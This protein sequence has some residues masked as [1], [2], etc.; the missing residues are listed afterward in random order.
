VLVTNEDAGGIDLDQFTLA[1]DITSSDTSIQ[2]SST[3]PSDT[4][5]SGTIRV[6]DGNTYKRVTY[7]GFSGDTFTGCSDVP[8]ATAGSNV[9]ISYIDTLAAATSEDFTVVYAADRSLFIRVRDG[10]ATPIKTFQT[11]ATLGAGGGSTTAIRTA[12]Y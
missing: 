4:P 1:A 6:F 11:T 3:I 5:S 2:V 10:G 7:T 8:D 12:D 9:F